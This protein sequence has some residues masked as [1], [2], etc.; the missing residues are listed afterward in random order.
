[1]ALPEPIHPLFDSIPERVVDGG[2][3]SQLQLEGI[4]YACQRHQVMLHDGSR[5]GFFLGD[6]AGVGKGRQIA[7]VIFDNFARSRRKHVWISCTS[8]LRMDA[9]RDLVDIGCN[10]K[11]IDGCH[12]LDKETRA[13]GLSKDCTEGVLFST[14]HSLISSGT[15]GKRPRLKQ[16]VDWCGGSEFAGCLMCVCIP[17]PPTTIPH[18]KGITPPFRPFM[19]RTRTDLKTIWLAN[20]QR[21]PAV[22]QPSFSHVRSFWGTMPKAPPFHPRCSILQSPQH[23]PGIL[24]RSSLH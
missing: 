16:I 2:G 15:K 10:V 9:T 24:Q 22:K 23:S 1:M 17:E 12:E 11:V 19:L 20:T 3:L 21:Y 14:Y 7:G 6:G 4:M 8:D 5:A 13:L 18:E